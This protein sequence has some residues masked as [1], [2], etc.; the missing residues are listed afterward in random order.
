MD[1]TKK[2]FIT[3]GTGFIGSVLIAKLLQQGF[4]VRI[5]KRGG[6]VNPSNVPLRQN[7][8]YVPGDI[9]DIESLR[10]GMAGCSYAFHLAAYAKNWGTNPKIYEQINIEGTR[11]VFTVAKELGMERIIWTSTIVT[12]GPTPKGVIG[13]ESMPR[14]TE[15]C[16]TEYERT[17][18]EMEKESAAW[19]KD[20]LPLV[21]VN[22]T[23]VFG[24]GLRS[25]SNSVTML[26]DD[27]RHG[28][29]PFLLNW[30]VNIGNYGFV[31]DVAEGHLLAMERGKIGE[32]YILGGE[33][34][35]L[36]DLF[37]TVDRID[38]KTHFQFKIFWV[39]PMLVAYFFQIR[40][41]LFGIY[42]PI[43][44][45]WVRTFLVDWAF[46][47]KKAEK[48]LEYR[49]TPFENAVQQTCQWLESDAHA[50]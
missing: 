16:L 29:F 3:G 44:P 35:S 8:E 4:S 21:I 25:E 49:I 26:I 23:R 2:V 50:S 40:A 11:N 31:N 27:Y 36:R 33:N 1:R 22:P 17:K 34:V 24:P 18:T 41:K 9:T 30:G 15:Q 20:G 14:I 46:S 48:E 12:L 13:D 38:D 39:I 42:P 43:T 47:C 32:R 10:R 5:L 37:Q 6:G 19:V 28:R 7:I 45:G